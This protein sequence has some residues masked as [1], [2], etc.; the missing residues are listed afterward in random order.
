MVDDR[1]EDGRQRRRRDIFVETQRQEFQAPSGATSSAYPAPDGASSF[2]RRR[3]TTTPRLRR[4]AAGCK[5]A[6]NP[7]GKFSA[8]GRPSFNFAK[9]N[10]D[11][12]RHPVKNCDRTTKSLATNRKANNDKIHLPLFSLCSRGA[13]VCR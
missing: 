6:P 8:R 3:S 5:P 1:C 2:C 11:S 4:Y 13:D 12:G 9:C 7:F 10:L